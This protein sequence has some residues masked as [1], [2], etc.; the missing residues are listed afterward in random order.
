[1]DSKYSM[2]NG[3]NGNTHAT[4][5][6]SHKFNLKRKWTSPATPN[7]SNN[8]FKKQCNNTNGGN[9]TN[10]HHGKQNDGGHTPKAVPQLS[11]MDQRRALPVFQVR[12]K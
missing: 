8:T 4:T 6:I 12:Q 10:S 9:G 3:R 1:M 11:L 7:H 2:F 5:P